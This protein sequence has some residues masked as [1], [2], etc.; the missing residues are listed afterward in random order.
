M[1]KQSGVLI[2]NGNEKL[3]ENGERRHCVRQ[4]VRF[5]YIELG[6]HNG[7]IVLNISEGGLA[8]QA[9][10]GIPSG[11][12][13]RVRF[14][15]RNDGEWIESSGKIAWTSASQKMVGISFVDLQDESRAQIRAWVSSDGDSDK[16]DET[17]NAVGVAI[18][19]RG[20]REFGTEPLPKAVNGNANKELGDPE[21]PNA[22]PVAIQAFPQVKDRRLDISPPNHTSAMAAIVSKSP[23]MREEGRSFSWSKS[24]WLIAVPVL[25]LIG[26]L[27][28][29][30]LEMGKRTVA[31][32]TEVSGEG[33]MGLKLERSGED[34]RLSWNPDAPVISNAT[35][36]RLLITDGN[37]RKFL[38]LDPSDLRGGTLVYTPS[39]SDVV[40]RLEV[41]RRDSTAA[42][43]ESVRISG[44]QP[45][46]SANEPPHLVSG[47]IRSG[48]L[49]IEPKLTAPALGSGGVEKATLESDRSD[50]AAAE[51][52]K[53][54]QSNGTNILASGGKIPA[55]PIVK[56]RSDL[57]VPVPP[58]GIGLLSPEPRVAVAPSV[59]PVPGEPPQFSNGFEAAQLI[60]KRNPT[61]P[62]SAIDGH[63]TGVVELHFR[64]GADGRVH[65]IAV[66]KGNP[67]LVTAAISAVE[68][69]RYKPAKLNGT[70]IETDGSAA[71]DFK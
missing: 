42:A 25:I 8:L 6:K 18:L 31:S 1:S 56:P 68:N 58:L 46:S 26:L 11:D 60:A 3:P 5:G 34:L 9:A 64:I 16:S 39:T 14:Q 33:H 53:I 48:S 13:P 52:R 61:Y 15:F 29:S 62:A 54:Q 40:L 49:L 19:D 2:G 67:V 32:K 41:D 22:E 70:V 51:P 47:I 65:S 24:D 45:I 37:S 27:T 43:T 44:G 21:R 10:R 28:I 17:G 63:F 50:L 69:W 38:E 35:K 59:I 55:Q 30:L 4:P 12:L 71:L 23:Q 57:A 66:V 36:A 20:L 7:G